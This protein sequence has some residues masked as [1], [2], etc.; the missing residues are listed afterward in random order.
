[1]NGSD[2]EFD[3]AFSFHSRD[4]GLATQLNDLVQDR[5][6][7]FL[8]SEQQKILAGTDG[9]KTFNAV[10]GKKARCVVVFCRAE[11]GET[12]FTRIEQT[13]IRNRAFNEG[14]DFT[15][16]IPTDNTVP[17]W[18]PKTQLYYG[19]ERFGLQGA[20]AVIEQRIQVLGGEPRVEGITDRAAR[21]QRGRDLEYARKKFRESPEGM[22]A[23]NDVFT[24]H[25]QPGGKGC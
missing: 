5:F 4:E 24:S 20:A 2:Y 6:K 25:C 14:Y 8:Y 17:P 9:E 1:M 16:F 7:T 23:A 18:L 19:L 12:P 13:A 22:K 3:V 10:F 21:L 11:W 15:L